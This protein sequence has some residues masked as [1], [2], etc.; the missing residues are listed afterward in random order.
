MEQT[1]NKPPFPGEQTD[2][3]SVSDEFKPRQLLK[4]FRLFAVAFFFL[5]VYK[6]FSNPILNVACASII[7]FAALIPT[8]LWCSGGGAGLPIYPLYAATHIWTYG[9]FLIGENSLLDRYY[10]ND[11]L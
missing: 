6:A 5:L 4:M 7:F 8:Y 2:G 3:P 11:I 1:I 10:A 9:L